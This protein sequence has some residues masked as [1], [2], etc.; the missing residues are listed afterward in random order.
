MSPKESFI[1]KDP[2]YHNIKIDFRSLK[3]QITFGMLEQ[4]NQK[5]TS[6]MRHFWNVL[7]LATL[8]MNYQITKREY[9]LLCKHMKL[10]TM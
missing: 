10:R 6:K 4:Q 9:E 2:L 7:L 8:A 5:C 3:E 1:Q